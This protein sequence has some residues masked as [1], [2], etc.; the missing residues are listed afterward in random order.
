[1]IVQ[2]ILSAIWN[3]RCSCHNRQNYG[4]LIAAVWF[5][6]SRTI[7]WECQ[8]WFIRSKKIIDLKL[9]FL[10]LPHYLVG[11]L[12]LR[13]VKL[14]WAFQYTLGCVQ[15]L[16]TGTFFSTHFV[17][18]LQFWSYD[19]HQMLWIANRTYRVPVL[20]LAALSL[21]VSGPCIKE[22]HWIGP[23]PLRVEFKE[24]GKQK[25]KDLLW[26]LTRVVQDLYKI[27]SLRV[28]K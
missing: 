11:S 17:L 13:F 12:E 21:L 15:A 3:L 10:Y 19:W 23:L 26:V 16:R 28:L 24:L 20:V 18:T 14:E 6:C 27:S 2:V 9:A 4:K 25:F 5:D 1:M 8:K 22:I 7:S